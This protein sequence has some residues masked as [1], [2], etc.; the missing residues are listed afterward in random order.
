MENVDNVWIILNLINIMIPNNQQS[1][2]ADLSMR[3]QLQPI[4]Q[5]SH[6]ISVNRMTQALLMASQH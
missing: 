1:M 4:L 3:E 2:K 6:E 5:E